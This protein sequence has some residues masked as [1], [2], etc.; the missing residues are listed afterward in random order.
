MAQKQKLVKNDCDKTY[1]VIV[2]GWTGEIEA[3]PKTYRPLRFVY[4]ES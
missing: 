2:A 1:T 3:E 4:V